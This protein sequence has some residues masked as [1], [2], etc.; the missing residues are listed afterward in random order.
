MRHGLTVALIGMFVFGFGYSAQAGQWEGVLTGISCAEKG[1]YCPAS[2]RGKEEVVMLE[3]NKTVLHL[4]G[5]DESYLLKHYGHK[6]R[7]IGEL[8]EE[9]GKKTVTVESLEHLEVVVN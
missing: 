3:E 4:K 6:V 9:M 5:Q 7:I 8:K 2:E 1:T